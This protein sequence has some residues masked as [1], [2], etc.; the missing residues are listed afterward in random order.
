LSK[1]SE[2]VFSLVSHV[3]VQLFAWEMVLPT[4]GLISARSHPKKM[5]MV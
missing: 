3:L 4:T 5:K 2:E 1:V